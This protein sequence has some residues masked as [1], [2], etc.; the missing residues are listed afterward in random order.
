M[1]KV[2]P[3]LLTLI[4]ASFLIGNSYAY[5]GGDL[6]SQ[7]KNSFDSFNLGQTSELL[8]VE[9]KLAPSH[10]PQLSKNFEL[11]QTSGIL[12]K[13]PPTSQQ[14]LDRYLIFGSGSLDDVNKI[15]NNL[16]QGVSSQNGF[17]SVAVLSETQAEQLKNKGY[18]VI[19]DFELKHLKNTITMVQELTLQL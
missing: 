15:N 17:F 14:R 19:E 6:V 1:H 3:L 16:L 4:F 8:T 9:P 10:N 5:L 12:K 11:E 18:Y 7:N 2:L 13:H